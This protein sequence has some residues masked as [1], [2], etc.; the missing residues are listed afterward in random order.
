MKILRELALTLAVIWITASAC[1]LIIV[2][3]GKL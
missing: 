3:S 2:F 1:E